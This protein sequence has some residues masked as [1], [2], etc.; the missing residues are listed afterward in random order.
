MNA[1]DWNEKFGSKPLIELTKEE[2]KYLGLNDLAPDWETIIFCKKTNLW[3]TKCTAYFSGN[4]IVKVINE[5]TQ[6]G[7][8]G[9][10]Y[11]KQLDEYD[12]RL[13]T[14]DRKLLL[15]LTPRGKA[16]KITPLCTGGCYPLRV[17]FYLELR[18]GKKDRHVSFQSPRQSAF[19]HRRK[20]CHCR[21][22]KRRGLSCFYGLLYQLLPGRL[23]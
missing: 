2:R 10:F 14:E 22:P 21:P 6:M 1:A 13:E 7:D 3:Y 8:D 15:P 16:K 12:T 5:I 17:F 20:G 19:S 11:S 23:L 9:T 4:T 18:A